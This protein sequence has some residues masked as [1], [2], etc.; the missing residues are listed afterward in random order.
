MENKEEFKTLLSKYIELNK[1]IKENTALKKELEESLKDILE[2]NETKRV[3][4]NNYT[5][6][7][8]KYEKLTPANSSVTL[9]MCYHKLLENEKTRS[10]ADD[11]LD[12]IRNELEKNKTTS[13]IRTLRVTEK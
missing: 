3:E 2:N 13:T 7:F 5:I 8:N 10:I 9:E 1:S 12:N 11:I 4:F 6:V